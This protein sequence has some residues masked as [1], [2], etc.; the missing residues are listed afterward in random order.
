MAG[1]RLLSPGLLASSPANFRG[2]PTPP[3]GLTNSIYRSPSLFRRRAKPDPSES[4]LCVV[5][6]HSPWVC[7][8]VA[9]M[10]PRH[11]ERGGWLSWAM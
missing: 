8:H 7:L 6:S 10:F 2:G 3:T 9:R 11:V 5:P 4:G 1:V